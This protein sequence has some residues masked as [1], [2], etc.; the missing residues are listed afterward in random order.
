M[1]TLKPGNIVVIKRYGAA[2]FAEV[3][4]IGALV[5]IRYF[6]GSG[7]NL[8]HESVPASRLRYVGECYNDVF[9]DEGFER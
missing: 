2:R 7:E 6:L 1:T 3:V 5:K 9:D 4:S 8:P